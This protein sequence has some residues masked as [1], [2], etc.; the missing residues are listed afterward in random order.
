MIVEMQI[1]KTEGSIL[2][3]LRDYDELGEEDDASQIQTSLQMELSTFVGG[4][5]K[6]TEI[7][8]SIADEASRIVAL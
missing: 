6:E 3:L 1:T 4:T 5:I 2:S 8:A 7:H